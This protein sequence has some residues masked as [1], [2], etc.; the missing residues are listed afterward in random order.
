[1]VKTFGVELVMVAV[2]TL[3]KEV[4]KPKRREAKKMVVACQL[5]KI[6]IAKTRKP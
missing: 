5:P 6:S 3:E 2:K 1:M 4:K